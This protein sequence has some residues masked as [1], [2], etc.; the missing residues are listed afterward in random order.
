MEYDEVLVGGQGLKELPRAGWEVVLSLLA[1]EVVLNSSG[2]PGL[3]V[4][5]GVFNDDIGCGGLEG[6]LDIE[7]LV[8]VIIGVNAALGFPEAFQ[9]NVVCQALE[10][11]VEFWFG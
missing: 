2:D 7:L 10:C 3:E 6:A 1:F 5:E 9:S 11:V 4:L 8:V